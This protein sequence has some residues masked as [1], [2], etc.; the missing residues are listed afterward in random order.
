M[1]KLII[2]FTFL[3]G[4]THLSL[5][6]LKLL[7]VNPISKHYSSIVR[8]LDSG[9]FP[10]KWML[11]AP[12]PPKF[13]HRFHYRCSLDNRDWSKWNDPVETHLSNHHKNRFSSDQ[14]L[15]R[16]YKDSI[17]YINNSHSLIGKELGC[18]DK[19]DRS[20]YDKTIKQ[21][22]QLKEYKSMTNIVKDLCNSEYQTNFKYIQFRSLTIYPIPYSKRNTPK[23][24]TKIITRHYPISKVGDVI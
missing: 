17:R 19:E 4:G 22:T 20:C 16:Y 10:Q 14:Y 2:L 11:F 21:L 9:F 12:E 18:T 23:S 7:P 24:N 5:Q 6:V 13:S 15:V 1:K 8:K 3:V